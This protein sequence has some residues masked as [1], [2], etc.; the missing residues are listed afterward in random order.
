MKKSDCF[1]KIK[2]AAF[3]FMVL[4]FQAYKVIGKDSTSIKPN[5]IYIVADDLG[6]GDLSIYGQK[7]FKTPN[8]D[9]LANEGMLFT[10]HYAGSTVCAPSRASLMTGLHTGHTEIRGNKG[11]NGGQFPLSSGAM[12]IPK[13]LKKAGYVTGAFG[14]WGLGY[15]GSNGDPLNQG[16]DEFFGYNSQTIAH[17]Y[18]P[19]ELY[20]NDKVV[21]MVENRETLQ[22][23]YA[24]DLI[25]QKTLDF[26]QN[27]KDTTFFLFVPS[28]IPHAELFAPEAYMK[29]FLKK[30]NQDSIYTSVYEPEHGYKGVNEPENPRYKNGGYGSQPMPRAAFAAMIKVLDDQ[31][32][33]ILNKLDELGLTDNTLVI[34]TSD[35]GP[36]KEGGADPDFFN[37]NGPFEGYKR[38][39]FEGGIRVPMLAKWPNKISA[40]SEVDHVSAFWDVLPTLCDVAE[41]DIPSDID[42]I[43]FLPTLL[44]E[45]SQKEHRSLYWEFHEQNGKQAVRKGDWKAIRLNTF[46]IDS[47]LLLFDLSKDPTERNNIAGQHPQ[48]LKEMV[49]IMDARSEDVNWPFPNPE[50]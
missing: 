26:I 14:K 4:L 35:N 25:H 39:L 28:I 7:K 15:P 23:L 37:S 20:D 19:R 1:S 47:E 24:P 38:D 49:E 3:I 50:K 6:Y 34:F 11:I 18:Y 12:T 45:K 29:L 2:Y 9:R 32:G 42:G 31:V 48:I 10:Q 17:N 16:F 33:E 27:H 41:V 44:G 36:H 46:N 40:G 8:I 5:I 22:G 13:M 21:E 43:S 30:T